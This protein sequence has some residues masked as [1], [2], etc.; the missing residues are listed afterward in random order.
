M[1]LNFLNRNNSGSNAEMSF[2]DHIE[3]L[4]GHLFRALLAV[5]IGSVIAYWKMDFFFDQIIM[6]PAHKEFITY[7]WLC[8]TSHALHMG[9]AMC[10][11]DINIKLI[12]TEMSS[13]FLMSFTI[14]FVIGFVLAFPYIFWEFW[15]FVKPA[16]T[17]KE[18]SKTRGVVFWVSLLFFLGIAFGYYLM[19]P[20][21]VNFF[22]AY[23][24]SPLIQNTF[25][26]SDYIDNIVSLVLGCGIVFQLPLVVYFLAKVGIVTPSFLRTYR[27]YAVVVI[28][29]I[30]AV[31]TPPDI[32]SMTIA[33]LPL[34]F[35]YE[36]SI[37]IAARVIK[38][39]KKKDAEEW[40]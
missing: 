24:L 9:N 10:L 26:I 32:V 20:Y 13:Q 19:A 12:S 38:E 3:A 39:K 11:E 40:G 36:V 16:L 2:I 1:A 7:R 37:W 21:S 25:M 29:L 31:I 30:A 34:L 23:T 6:G 18:V 28:L 27:K 35:L 4:R 14:A 5:L 15:R 8:E 33:S 17:E 22:A